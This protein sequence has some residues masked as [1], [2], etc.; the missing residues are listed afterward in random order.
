M[1]TVEILQK[2][3]VDPIDREA[4]CIEPK[5]SI[6]MTRFQNKKDGDNSMNARCG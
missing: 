1:V 2:L 6:M 3:S 4:P 5:K